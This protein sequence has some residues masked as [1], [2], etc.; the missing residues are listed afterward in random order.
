M[1]ITVIV[2]NII[3]V[4]VATN[5]MIKTTTITAGYYHCDEQHCIIIISFLRLNITFYN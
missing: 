4:A 1:K 2:V 5:I 3:V